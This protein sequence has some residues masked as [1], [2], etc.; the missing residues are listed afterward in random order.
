MPAAYTRV[1]VPAAAQVL[2]ILR[3]LGQQAGPVSASA[4][5]RD[6][7]LPRSTTYHL[8]AALV[9]DGFAVHLP[10]E[11]RYALGATAHEL[12]T[13]YARQAP[14]Q[15][16]ARF[17]LRRLVAQTRFTA[18]LA[19]LQGTDVI[20]VIEERAPRQQPLVTDAGIRLPAHRTA[21]GRVLLAGMT[22]AQLRA[23]YP[24]PGA[25][26][27]SRSSG[28]RLPGLL[29]EVR[30]R[31]YAWEEDEVTEGFSSIAVPVPDRS[32]HAVAGLTL[33]APNRAPVPGIEALADQVLPALLRCAA[34]LSRRL[35][36]RPQPASNV[37]GIPDVTTGA[38]V[39]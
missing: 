20:Y 18:H 24:D 25:V 1:Q 32:G 14:L 10:E 36:A 33:T 23:L 27:S 22:G 34:E 5:A 30:R 19:V 8:L 17:P 29:E 6:L 13:G 21:S 39:P 2:A 15:R 9:G 7:S 28:T 4:V 38:D 12:G 31:G 16:I 37:S 26:R 3:Y 11:R 35:G